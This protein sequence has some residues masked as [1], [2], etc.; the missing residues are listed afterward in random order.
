MRIVV[1]FAMFV[2]AT[3]AAAKT[4]SGQGRVCGAKNKCDTGLTC[5]AKYEGKSTCELVCTSNTKC[6][7]DQRC[8]RDGAQSVCRPINDADGLVSPIPRR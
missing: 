8:V 1:V 2:V 4:P 3:G 5:V 7:E 6:P